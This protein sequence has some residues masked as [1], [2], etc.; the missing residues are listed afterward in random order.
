MT[1]PTADYLDACER[2]LAAARSQ[3]A[4]ISQ[5][6]DW[7]AETILAGR[8]VHLFGAGHSRIMVE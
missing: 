2:M 7:F 1:L 5:V 8:M 6:A 3:T 4:K